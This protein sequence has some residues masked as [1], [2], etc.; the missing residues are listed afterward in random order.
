MVKPISL[1]IRANEA[2]AHAREI[3]RRFDAERRVKFQAAKAYLAVSE[4][5]SAAGP[6]L[7]AMNV[8]DRDRW[9]QEVRSIEKKLLEIGR[10]GL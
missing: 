3:L 7:R 4:M 10:R 2:T 6:K 9:E 5:R 1:R 8:R